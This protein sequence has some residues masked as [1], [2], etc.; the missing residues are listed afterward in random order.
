[1]P[2]SGASAGC[3]LFQGGT[4]SCRSGSVTGVGTAAGSC[5]N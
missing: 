2:A 5:G 1:L 4:C 3:W